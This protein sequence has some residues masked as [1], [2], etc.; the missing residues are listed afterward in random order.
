MASRL[1]E[2]LDKPYLEE[3][4]RLSPDD[5]APSFGTVIRALVDQHASGAWPYYRPEVFF[6]NTE[7][8]EGFAEIIKNI[9][10]TL[11]SRGVDGIFLDL[12]MG[13]G[14]THLLTLLLHL[15]ASCRFN[16]NV[17]TRYIRDYGKKTG[18]NLELA[19]NTIVIA[20]DM[21]TPES[22]YEYLKLTAGILRWAGA[23][24]AANHIEE[25]LSNRRLPD[26]VKLA[27]SIPL[28]NH[29]LILIDELHY[30]AILGTRSSRE[31]V[32]EFLK[33]VSS[34]MSY[35]KEIQKEK[36]GGVALVVASARRDFVR[37]SEIKTV[38]EDKD[39]AGV[40]EAFID[41]LERVK[42]LAASRWMS[43]AEAQRIIARRLK[44]GKPFNEVFHESFNG[45]IERVI[46]ADSDFPDAHH[47]RSL[48][49]A[50]AI[51]ALNALESN[52][53]I[54]SP[55]HF[56]DTVVTVLLGD[57]DIARRYRAV[58]SEILNKLESM[59][60]TGKKGL[61]RLAVN[62]VFTGTIVGD[63]KK[64]IEMVRVAK[65]RE[66]SDEAIPLVRELEL[67]E[68]LTKVHGYRDSD[69]VDVVKDLE[70]IHPNIHSVKLVGGAHAYFV[71]P[72]RNVKAIYRDI[73]ARNRYNY[74]NNEKNV[75]EKLSE[76]VNELALNEALVQQSVVGNLNDLDKTPHSRDKLYI[77]IYFNAPLLSQSKWDETKGDGTFS[78]M[79]NE[80]REYLRR[81]AM[82]NV[83]F[84]LP[85]IKESLIRDM[86]DYLA[87]EDA[88]S[89]IINTY[90]V[91]VEKDESTR[92]SEEDE[93]F[94]ELLKIEFKDIVAEVVAKINDA[95]ASF[96]RAVA[97]LPDKALYYMPSGEVREAD[98]KL[99][100][101]KREVSGLEDVHRAIDIM[102][103]RRMDIIEN[104]AKELYQWI[105]QGPISFIT[106]ESDALRVIYSTVTEDLKSLNKYRLCKDHTVL[107]K[108]EK[109]YYIP[110]SFIEKAFQ[111]VGEEVRKSFEKDYTVRTVIDGTCME[112]VL[113]PKGAIAVVNQPVR[114]SVLPPRPSTATS[115][116]EIIDSVAE[117]GGGVV[118]IEI[119]VTK[120][121]YELVKETLSQIMKYV[122][123]KD[124]SR[125]GAGS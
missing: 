20:A 86:A 88:T 23:I 81:K 30:S 61:L 84:V 103:S 45:F 79:L 13:S 27:Q 34:L 99:T 70:S 92:R 113:E 124:Y 60:N 64:I 35:R 37:W 29:I 89:H 22:I 114:A 72:S 85:R 120:D 96:S 110:P 6:D 74:L 50:F 108:G 8:T 32:K 38:F 78:R 101:V 56:S 54:V 39:F 4:I 100:P 21:R 66:V 123:I 82:H 1:K 73:I 15:F 83:V 12:D 106:S 87:V 31:I 5:L 102:R 46:K 65:T 14:K 69:V 7:L 118:T 105:S 115:I 90:L 28:K 26:P 116:M 91:K 122:K 3:I 67:K 93:L 104:T 11:S 53:P 119:E 97:S 62:I 76:Y 57:S 111:S 63:A 9:V 44:L 117:N 109:S 25:S 18:F 48:I 125:K 52:A 68:I 40:L 59:E 94:R 2:V 71:A 17:C 58:Y 51:Y 95:L 80:A 98:V 24:D 19:E 55:A 43:N 33:F 75:V 41:Q 77:Y 121:N 42:G 112:I 49:K 16:P 107:Q 36:R 47:M 10:N